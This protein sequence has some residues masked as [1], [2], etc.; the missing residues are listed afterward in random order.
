MANQ[1]QFAADILAAVGGKEN[2]SSVTHCMTRLRFVLKDESL[3]NDEKIK[4][5]QGVITVVRAGGQVQIVVGTTVDKTY[6]EVC[7]QGNFSA[8]D[9]IDENLDRPKEKLTPK[10]LMNNILGAISG[11]ITPVLPVFIVAGIFKMLATLLG[12]DNLGLL[13]E[14]NQFYILCNLVN[15]AGYYFLPFCIAYSASKKFKC[16]T[17]LAIMFVGIMIHPDMLAIVESGETFAVFGIPMH[18]VNYTQAVF[19]VI[20]IVWIM[21]YVEKLV[22]KIVPDLLRTIGVPVLTMAIMLPLG[23]CVFGP[24][25]SIVMDGVANVLV[26]M[27][28]NIGIPSMVIIAALWAIVIVFG[29]HVP[30]MQALLPSWLEM[31]FD[32]IVSPATVAHNSA[33]MGV[34]LSYALRSKGKENKSLGWSCFVTT[35]SA[36]V[37]E[38]YLYGIY[39]RDRRALIYNAIGAAAGACTM[40]LLGAKIVIFSGV[41]FPILNFLRFGEYAIP[42]AIGLFVAFAVSLVLGLLFGYEGTEKKPLHEKQKGTSKD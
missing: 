17:I 24:I 38:P 21:S 15:N 39:L 26:W 25:C 12:P 4:A 40:G 19:P 5:I 30:I 8:L 20:I 13:A 29:V 34:E 14:D 6:D 7:R 33:V 37:S 1:T 18:S 36:N 10:R 22:K 32:A 11:S 28:N 16:N 35:F 27:T 23:L 2:V 9:A 3:A 31:G 41:G 42:G